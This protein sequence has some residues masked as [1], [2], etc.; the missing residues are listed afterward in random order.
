MWCVSGMTE[1]GMRNRRACLGCQDAICYEECKSVKA[2]ALAD[3]T[4]DT[5]YAGKGAYYSARVLARLLAENFEELHGMEDRQ[6]QFNVITNVRTELYKICDEYGVSM[7][8]I[9]STLV[10]VAIDESTGEYIAV[11][12]GD[13][14]IDVRDADGESEE[15]TISWPENGRSGNTTYLTS[16][17]GAGKHVRITRGTV[18]DIGEFRLLSDG[19]EEAESEGEDHIDDKSFIALTFM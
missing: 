13:G 1:T 8:Q 16:M 15:Y 2:I 3:G 19:W 4:G 7:S 17:K 18:G 9:H 11:H 14:R 6:V 10:G 5:D 12:L